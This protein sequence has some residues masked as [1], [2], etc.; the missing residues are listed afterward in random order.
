MA[1]IT[2]IVQG[3]AMSYHKNDGL[4][5]ILFPFGDSHTIEFKENL[6]DNGLSLAKPNRYI[7]ITTENAESSFAAADNY[8]DFLDLTDEYSHSNGVRLKEDWEEKAVLMSV[9]NAKFSVHK[10]TECEHFMLKDT[11]VTSLPRKIGYSGKF[12]IISESITVHV[13]NHP[14]FPKVFDTDCTLI[15]DN[16]CYDDKPKTRGDFEMVYNV[17]E[18]AQNSVR[19]FTVATVPENSYE[20]IRLG[21]TFIPKPEEACYRDPLNKGL[22]C[23]LVK[24]SRTEN[25]L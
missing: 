13:D 23:H 5:K 22:P 11:I 8:E 1:K 12:E 20:S 2:I 17:I 24:I 9:E 16:D 15:F 7:R 18:D 10:Y 4:W 3:I 14:E 6:N 25:L 19:Q 21:A